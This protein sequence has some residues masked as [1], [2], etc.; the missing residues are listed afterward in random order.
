VVVHL[1]ST[2]KCAYCQGERWIF[3]RKNCLIK[4]S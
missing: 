2:T 4:G 3:L 1:L